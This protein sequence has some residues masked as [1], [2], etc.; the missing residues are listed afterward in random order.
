MPSVSEPFGI[1]PLE[2]MQCGTPSII[3]KQSGCGEILENVI[4]VD[5]WD[6]NAMADAIYSICTNPSLFQFLQEEGKKEVDGIT[7]EK[8][9]LKHRAIYEELI[10]NNSK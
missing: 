5:Y 2:A 8:V 7:W 6:I 4:K 9:G 1:A 10:R 3:S